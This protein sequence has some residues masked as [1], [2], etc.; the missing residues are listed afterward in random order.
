MR[1]LIFELAA[2]GRRK[3]AS[4]SRRIQRLI[5]TIDILMA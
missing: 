4:I 3:K 2:C 1:W 5:L